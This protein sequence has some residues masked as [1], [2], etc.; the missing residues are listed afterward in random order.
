MAKMRGAETLSPRL[1][2]LR[3]HLALFPETRRTVSVGGAVAAVVAV[4]LGTVVTLARLSGPAPYRTLYAEDGL[5]Y[6]SQSVMKSSLGAWTTGYNGYIQ[7]PSR[8][9]AA[10]T[11]PFGIE[12]APAVFAFASAVILSLVALVV[13]WASDGYITSTPVRVVLAASL[14]VLPVGQAEV[15]TN[16]A[17]LHWYFIFAS[18][19]VLLWN[20]ERNWELAVGCVVVALAGMSDPLTV[21]LLPIALLRFVALDR[22]R[23]QLPTAAFA[24]GLA[25]QFLGMLLTRTDRS[26]AEYANPLKLPVWYVFHVGGRSLL[27]SEVL[28]QQTAK[29]L[30]VSAI[31]MLAMAAVV[32]F[33]VRPI[34]SRRGQV[35]LLAVVFS[36]AF[37]AI[38]T[39]L[40]GLAGPRYEVLPVLLVYSALALG[41]DGIIAGVRSVPVRALAAVLVV[42]LVVAWGIG[43]RFSSSRSVGPTWHTALRRAADR[44]EATDQR[45]IRIEVVPHDGFWTVL[46]PCRRVIDAVRN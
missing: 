4:V 7:L 8:G 19:W 3:R 13:F 40:T 21:L 37:F 28:D 26:F 12:A 43:L 16:S 23:K 30:V 36:G 38:S 14:V 46:L 41:V 34:T 17:G 15:Y 25:I 11:A 33:G 20:P 2:A 42:V 35:A 22:G 5:I 44:C 45:L 9:I 6:L 39:F 10:L 31:V 24:V 1:T 27:G 18:F 29:T 32:W